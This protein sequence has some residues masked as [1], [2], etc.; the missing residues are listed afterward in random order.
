MFDLS[1]KLREFRRRKGMTQEEVAKALDVAPQTV[2]KWEREETLPDVAM[3]PA[4][5]NLYAVTTDALLGMDQL[6]ER[7][8]R[9]EVYTTARSFLKQKNWEGAIA[10][11]QE[12]LQSWPDDAGILTD[13]AMAM[14]LSG[15]SYQ[16][17]KAA[18]LCES[19]LHTYANPK[20]Q[21]TARAALCYIYAKSGARERAKLAAN[22]LPPMRESREV[23]I[24]NLTEG[25]SLDALLFELSVGEKME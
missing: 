5:A 20:L 11:Y 13:M 19:I 21:H 14:A 15:G 3:L 25:C 24:K 4:I 6:H 22:H 17:A 16:L 2:S 10:V 18:E 8:R 9:G 7:A 12:A 1:E 23:V